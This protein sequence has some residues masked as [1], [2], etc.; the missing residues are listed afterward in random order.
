MIRLGIVVEGAT[1]EAFVRSILSP[2]LRAF[3]VDAKASSINGSVNLNRIVNEMAKFS[4]SFDAVTSLIDFYGFGPPRDATADDLQA[5][6]DGEL[7]SRV[8]PGVHVF[9]YVQMHEFEALLFADVN[10]FAVIAGAPAN[11]VARLRSIRAQF[12]TPEDINDSPA[13]APSKR[14]KEEHPR[15]GKV[16]GGRAVAEEI[17]LAGIRAECP[18]FDAWVARLEA[19]GEPGRGR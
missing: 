19:L 5:R 4:H 17:G 11:L 8:K 18:R 15:Y 16:M 6:I 9:S 13:T 2:H 12:P 7:A 10:G 14:I 1:E 3:R